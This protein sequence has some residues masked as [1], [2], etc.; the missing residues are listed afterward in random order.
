MTSFATVLWRICRRSRTK[1]WT[2]VATELILG[3]H[4]LFKR[5]FPLVSATVYA[6]PLA[7]VLAS[8][9]RIFGFLEIETGCVLTG[10][11]LYLLRHTI[12]SMDGMKIIRG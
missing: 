4:V 10:L 2:I 7:V 1:F 3:T 9:H 8:A 12:Q 5:Y 11:R 6:D